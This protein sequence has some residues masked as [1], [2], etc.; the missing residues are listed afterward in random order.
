VT[1]YL[2]SDQYLRL[3]AGRLPLDSEEGREIRI[4]GERGRAAGLNRIFG[5]IANE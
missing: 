3:L 1:L 4:E 5:G 2:S